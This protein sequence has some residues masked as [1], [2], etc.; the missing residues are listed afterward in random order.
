[1]IELQKKIHFIIIYFD[2][3]TSIEKTSCLT[4]KVLA[5]LNLTQNFS[6]HYKLRRKGAVKHRG[7]PFQSSL[8]LQYVDSLFVVSQ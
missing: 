7:G 3:L 1:M 6:P 5:T 4:P 8:T 2:I